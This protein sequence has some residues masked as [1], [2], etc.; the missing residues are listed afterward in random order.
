VLFGYA[1]A[2]LSAP[3]LPLAEKHGIPLF[4]PFTGADAIHERSRLVYTVRASYRDEMRAIVSMWG[5]VGLTRF[6]IV[7]HT[8]SRPLHH[9]LIGAATVILTLIVLSA[10]RTSRP[11]R[12]CSK[13]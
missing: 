5:G 2:T 9:L 12:R 8:M 6:A 1:S 11:C 4:A 10:G 13:A 7:H 3:A